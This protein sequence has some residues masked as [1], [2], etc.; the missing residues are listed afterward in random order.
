MAPGNKRYRVIVKKAAEKAID[1][2]PSKIRTRIV[3]AINDLG[4]EPR[5]DGCKK[6]SLD[7]R[8]RIRIGDYRI[9]YEIEDEI[10]LVLVVRVGHR[11][12]VYR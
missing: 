4:D 8:Y 11:R 10:L 7:A 5:P 2:L 3:I 9:V 12:D 1:S 6:M